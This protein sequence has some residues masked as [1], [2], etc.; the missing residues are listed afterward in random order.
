MNISADLNKNVNPGRMVCAESDPR[1]RVFEQ[2]IHEEPAPKE[3]PLGGKGQAGQGRVWFQVKSLLS[4]AYI[5][6]RKRS[7]SSTL[8]HLWP[9]G[10]SSTPKHFWTLSGGKLNDSSGR[11]PVESVWRNWQEKHRSLWGVALRWGG[12]GKEKKM[13]I[14]DLIFVA[15]CSIDFVGEPNNCQNLRACI[16]VKYFVLKWTVIPSS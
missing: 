13:S 16:C 3:K 8:P 1:R 6:S 9:P 15:I 14:R 4:K 2:V 5:W 11:S 7:W 10:G 12:K